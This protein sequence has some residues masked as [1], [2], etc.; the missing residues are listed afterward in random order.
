VEIVSRQK[1]VLKSPQSKRFAPLR[2]FENREASGLRACS[3][4]LSIR[5]LSAILLLPIYLRAV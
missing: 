3:P 5:N 2:G 1:A 4:P